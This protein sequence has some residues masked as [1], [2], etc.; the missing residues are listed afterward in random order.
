MVLRPLACVL[1][2]P[3]SWSICEVTLLDI[4]E[5]LDTYVVEEQEGM[6][7]HALAM[8]VKLTIGCLPLFRSGAVVTLQCV[9]LV[10][11]SHDLS[12]HKQVQLIMAHLSE[13]ASEGLIVLH[14]EEH[15][16]WSLLGSKVTAIPPANKVFDQVVLSVIQLPHRCRQLTHL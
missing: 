3:H 11:V 9:G 6:L 8:V 16:T 12:H 7:A 4:H 1:V 5:P 10:A 13:G 15:R 14:W 2:Y